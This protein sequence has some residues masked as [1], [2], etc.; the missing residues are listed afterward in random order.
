MGK[1][2]EQF[3]YKSISESVDKTVDEY[4]KKYTPKKGRRF[5]VNKIT[6]EVG[7]TI[8][9]DGVFAFEISN[10]IP[11]GEI[12]EKYTI[13]DYFNDVKKSLASLKSK[14]AEVDMDEIVRR[15]VENE[16]KTRDYVRLKFSYKL[17]SLYDDKAIVTLC[18][19]IKSG[20]SDVD[21]SDLP[22]E[23]SIV[24]GL[25]IRM[26]GEKSHAICTQ[27]IDDLMKA[28]DEV[29]KK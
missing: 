1:L 21:I 22:S 17:E 28:N 6:Y 20:K 9:Q 7:E 4:Q 19:D 15:G 25:A 10:K 2:R 3:F 29:R 14:P 24:G 26:V 13:N 23:R 16:V 8:V 12:S 11:E 27:G 5:N 18:E